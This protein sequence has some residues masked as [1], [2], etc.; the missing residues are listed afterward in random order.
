MHERNLTLKKITGEIYMNL[1]VSKENSLTLAPA[2]RSVSAQSSLS[3]NT[4][5]T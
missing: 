4:L 2:L 5:Y 1:N 3:P